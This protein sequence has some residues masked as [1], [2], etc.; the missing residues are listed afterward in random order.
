MSQDHLNQAFVTLNCSLLQY[1]GENSPWTSST[2]EAV[3]EQLDAVVKLQRA[4]IQ[5]LAD[6]IVN[7][8]GF[9]PRT[10][11]PAEYTDLQYLSLSY[12]IG[13]LIGDQ[14]TVLKEIEQERKSLSNDP[15]A[16]DM[17]AQLEVGVSK[18][19]QTLKEIESR[20]S[21]KEETPAAG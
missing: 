15:G 20:L 18:M 5:R 21:P 8:H 9:V 19:I 10:N 13:R 11:Y 3:A 2:D 12:L 16:S 14:Q 4:Q 7:R 17:L 1:V 6:F